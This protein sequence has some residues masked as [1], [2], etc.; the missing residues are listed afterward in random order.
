MGGFNLGWAPADHQDFL[1]LYTKYGDLWATSLSF[2]N[3]LM[4][5]VAN[6]SVEDVKEHVEFYWKSILLNA[7]KKELIKNYK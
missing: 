2:M 5:V 4:G 6:I 1:W 3:E 7:E